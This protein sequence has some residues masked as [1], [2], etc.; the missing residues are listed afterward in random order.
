MSGDIEVVAEPED[1]TAAWLTRALGSTGEFTVTA[2]EST[3]IGTG[4]MGSSFRLQ[5]TYRGDPGDRP[6]TIVAPQALFLMNGSPVLKTS[7]K[8]AELLIGQTVDP[9]ERIAAAFERAFGRPPTVDDRTRSMAFLAKADQ[10]YAPHEADA[11]A[12]EVKVWQSF[13][14]ALMSTNEFVYVD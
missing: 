13:C 9:S 3:P 12:R 11:K 14:K 5:L 4:Q 10:A 6:S 8:L 7:R 1:L 2:V